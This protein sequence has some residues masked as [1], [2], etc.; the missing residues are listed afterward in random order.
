MINDSPPQ[1]E[2]EVV[3]VG[4]SLKGVPRAVI[5]VQNRRELAGVL[6]LLCY[7]GRLWGG[8]KLRGAEMAAPGK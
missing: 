5:F 4:L 2:L 1:D 6:L 7:N 8:R 3:S